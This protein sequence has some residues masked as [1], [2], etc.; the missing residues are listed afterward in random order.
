MNRSKR[1]KEG[2]TFS[3][4]VVKKN[5]GYFECDNEQ[6]VLRSDPHSQWK[7]EQK[8]HAIAWA[9]NKKAK[10]VPVYYRVIQRPINHSAESPD[11]LSCAEMRRLLDRGRELQAKLEPRLA[12]MTDVTPVNYQISKSKIEPIDKSYNCTNEFCTF[13]HNGEL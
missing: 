13:G 10:I 6:F 4:Y 7:E 5:G 2:W 8:K 11:S 1:K 12:Q 3:H 9:E